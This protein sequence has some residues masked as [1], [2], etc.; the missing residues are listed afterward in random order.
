MAG[1]KRNSAS[2][3]GAGAKRARGR[4]ASPCTNDDEAGP[5]NAAGPEV[6]AAPEQS[7]RELLAIMQAADAS[8]AAAINPDAAEPAPARAP[9]APA[10]RTAAHIAAR[11]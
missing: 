6:A 9:R 2:D 11:R 5:S 8:K 1:S 7:S 4:G 10:R 3:A